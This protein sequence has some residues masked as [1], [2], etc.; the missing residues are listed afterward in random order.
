MTQKLI[1]DN[2]LDGISGAKVTGA[3]ANATLAA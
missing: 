3:V 1:T 2:Q